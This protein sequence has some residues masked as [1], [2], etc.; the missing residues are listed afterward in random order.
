ML[1]KYVSFRDEIIL[2]VKKPERAIFTV[3]LFVGEFHELY[4]FRST[5]DTPSHP[6][7]SLYIQVNLHL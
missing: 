2:K 5:F 1:Y 7:H 4:S 3:K 6:S